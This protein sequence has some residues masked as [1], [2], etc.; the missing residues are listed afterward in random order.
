MPF[1]TK[2]SF[3]F[4][5]HSEMFE[6]TISNY[7]L[8]KKCWSVSIGTAGGGINFGCKFTWTVKLFHCSFAICSETWVCGV[9]RDFARRFT[10]IVHGVRYRYAS[11]T[12]LQT[13]VDT[14][15]ADWLVYSWPRR[16]EL[17]RFNDK[18]CPLPVVQYNI[19]RTSHE[20]QGRCSICDTCFLATSTQ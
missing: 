17:N 10:K 9:S 6:I 15:P 12:T 14:P 3:L 4:A 20:R 2:I 5:V 8:V 18:G 13:P 19:H 11:D 16:D 7:K 1:L